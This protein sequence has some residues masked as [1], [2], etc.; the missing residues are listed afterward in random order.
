MSV[1]YLLHF[2]R[3]FKHARHYLGWTEDLDRRLA[4]HRA[5]R[6]SPPLVAAAIADGITFELAATWPGDRTKERP[7]H[8]YKNSPGRL[9]PICR[10][11]RAGE[12]CHSNQPAGERG[13]ARPSVARTRAGGV[14]IGPAPGGA[15]PKGGRPWP[16][17][18]SV[19]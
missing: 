8:R 6:G 5:G 3:S 2:E 9:C 12:S 16:A 14:G 13:R 18:A 11:E 17:Q 15:Q 4:Q 1:I 10:V 19:S 7:L